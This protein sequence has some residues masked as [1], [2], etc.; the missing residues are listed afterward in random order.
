[1]FVSSAIPTVLPKPEHSGDLC[2]QAQTICCLDRFEGL[3]IA[4]M[5]DVALVAE[6]GTGH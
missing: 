4:G 1:M 2:L 6:K 5:V 3:E